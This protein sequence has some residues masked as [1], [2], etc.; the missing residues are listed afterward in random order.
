MKARW[1]QSIAT[2]I[3]ATALLALIGVTGGIAAQTKALAAPRSAAPAIRPNPAVPPAAPGAAFDTAARYAL[4]TEADTNTVLFAKNADARMAPASMSKLMTAYVVFSML[5]EGRI[6]LGDELPVSEKAWRMGG[7]KMFVGVNSRLKIDDLI[8]GMIVQSGNDACIVL[9]EGL[10]GSEDAFVEKMNDMAQKIGL[11]DSH[12]ANVTGLPDPN[13][14]MT[15]QDLTTLGLHI[16]ND[17]PQYYHYFSEKDFSFNNIDQG[18]RNPL[19]YKDIG[20]DGLKTGH[21]D[22]SGYSL[23]GSIV[24]GDRRV[25]V[26][27]SGLA[28]MKDRASESERLAEWAFREFNNYKLFAAGEKVDDANVWLGRDSRVGMTIDKD[29]TVT[30]PRR[31]RHDMKVAVDYSDPVPAPIKQG[32]VIGKVTVT[33]PGA[34][35]VER[36]LYAAADVPPIGTIGR[37]ATLAG[38]LIWGTRH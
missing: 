26:V 27:V 11:K 18:N 30:M 6:T 20:A 12:F 31:S 37:M 16:I 25:I 36:P 19:L 7:S 14:W 4:I 10:A 33:A 5:K 13:E 32:D 21:T 3:T 22:E 8:R 23:I 35:T 34:D 9:A 1:R 29:L 24:R 2:T 38:Y 15:A 17:Y 28:S